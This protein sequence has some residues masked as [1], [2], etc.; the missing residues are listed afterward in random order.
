MRAGNVKMGKRTKGK[1]GCV[2]VVKANSSTAVRAV[3]VAF[4]SLS[5]VVLSVFT[6]LFA[7][8]GDWVIEFSEPKN[9]DESRMQSL[10]QEEGALLDMVALL[11]SLFR[12]VE[13]V[14]VLVGADDG[15][16]YEGGTEIVTLPYQF[17][18]DIEQKFKNHGDPERVD[19]EALDDIVLDVVMHT[20]FH[21]LGHVLMAQHQ[22]PLFYEE[23]DVVDSLANLLLLEYT[24]YG[25]EVATSAA[26]MFRLEHEGIE[27]FE[28]A[29]FWDEHSFDLQRHYDVYCSIYGAYPEENKSLIDT[30]FDGDEDQAELCIDNYERIRESWQPLLEPILITD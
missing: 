20:L 10:L 14:T 6:P 19:L 22:L 17:A 15:P 5:L 25:T 9:S 3:G 29:D 23:E 12:L 18:L 2:E 24:E 13:P 1:I 7:G 21:E 26:E 27:T 4:L 28:A 11:E 16:Y 30:V 8:E